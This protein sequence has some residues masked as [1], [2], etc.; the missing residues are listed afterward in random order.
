[1]ELRKCAHKTKVLFVICIC[2]VVCIQRKIQV[3]NNA[4]ETLLKCEIFEV[5]TYIGLK[6]VWSKANQ[7]TPSCYRDRSI[8]EYEY[9]LIFCLY[10]FHVELHQK[11]QSGVASS[12]LNAL[13]RTAPIE[14]VDKLA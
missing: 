7:K 9:V 14:T 2:D 8:Q 4:V 13:V 5:T 6:A 12:N 11:I 3:I 10:F 1:M